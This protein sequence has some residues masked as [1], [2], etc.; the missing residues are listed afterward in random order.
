MFY[1]FLFCKVFKSQKEVT[2]CE[3]SIRTNG[4]RNKIKKGFEVTTGSEQNTINIIE[5]TVDM[6]I[7]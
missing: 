1:T 5:R 3:A 4:S 6:M 7:K 2:K